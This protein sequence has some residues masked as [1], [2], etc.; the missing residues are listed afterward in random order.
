[1]MK[2]DIMTIELRKDEQVLDDRGAN[3]FRGLE[4]VGG[5]LKTTNQRLIFE[6]H[7]FNIQKQTLEVPLNQILEVKP[8]NTWGI[9]PNGVLIKMISGQEY[10]LVVWNR[11]KLIELINKI[12]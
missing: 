4:G 10:K 6:P 2:F 9:V 7:L 11:K 3:L 1:M 5:R 12:K 8:R